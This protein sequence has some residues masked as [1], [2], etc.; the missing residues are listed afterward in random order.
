MK[1]ILMTISMKMMND[2]VSKW[3][4]INPLTIQ[5]RR[6]IKEGLDLNMSYSQIAAHAGRGKSVVMRES[7]RLGKIKDYDPEKAQK[8]FEAKQKLVGIKKK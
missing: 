5:Q 8:D 6:L 3:K 4:T 7:K 2:M 1:T